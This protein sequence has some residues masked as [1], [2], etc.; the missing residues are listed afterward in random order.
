[1][2]QLI[3]STSDF[4][5][6][7]PGDPAARLLAGPAGPE[8][9]TSHSRR[10]GA[11]SGWQGAGA[12]LAAEITRS[13]LTGRGGGH[14][15]LARKIA[16]ALAAGAGGSVVVNVTESEPA[17]VKDRELSSLRPNLVIDGAVAVALASGATRAILASHHHSVLASIVDAMRDRPAG[18]RCGIDVEVVPVPDRYIAGESGALLSFLGHGPG[19][20]ERRDRPA[21]ER[22]LAG[23]PTVVCNAETAAH[24]ALIG[25][26]GAG[27]FR[28]AGSAGTPG[29]TLVT[30]AGDVPAGPHVVELIRP[31]RLGDLLAVAGEW[32]AVLVGGYGGRWVSRHEAE[33]MV[34]DASWM[35][36][37][38]VPLGCGLLAVLGPDRCPIVQA[39]A[40]LSWLVDQRAGQ[41]GACHHGLPLVAEAVAEVA[42]GHGRPARARRKVAALGLSV[43]NSGLCH[44]PDSAMDNAESLLAGFEHEM[45]LH[46]KGDCVAPDDDRPFVP[47]PPPGTGSPE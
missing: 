42:A 2:T 17:S 19:L 41:C 22:G 6:C 16:A 12:D 29:S 23:R 39:S 25:R 38:G 45:K 31:Q 26:F 34:V 24:T 4:T 3:T 7:G 8:S 27:W 44:L 46:R 21:A 40:V 37:H 43:R 33:D 14:F 20:P 15:P 11:I 5:V 13:G 28:E 9:W 10:L 47:L 32:Q 35:R 1:M 18:E 36:D 30:L